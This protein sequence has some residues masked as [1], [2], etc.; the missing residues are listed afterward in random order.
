MFKLFT[1]RQYSKIC[2]AV[3]LSSMLFSIATILT[4][5]S[6]FLILSNSLLVM[7]FIL[8]GVTAAKTG[9]RFLSLIKPHWT[10]K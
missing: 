6:V 2:F 9:H 4:H 1:L 3:F 10:G 8:F 5:K 7:G